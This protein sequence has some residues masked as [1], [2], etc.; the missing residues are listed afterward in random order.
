MN[1]AIAFDDVLIVPEFSTIRSRKDVDLSTSMFGRR[2]SLPIISANMDTITQAPMAMAMDEAGGAGVLHRFWSIEDN[3]KEYQKFKKAICSV[4]I[5]KLELERAEALVSNGCNALIVDVAHGAQLSVVEQVIELRKLLGTNLYITVG[6]FATGNSIND[7]KYRLGKY[8]ADAWKSGIGGGC[9][10]GDTR[11]LMSDGSYKDIK[12]IKIHDKVINMN[13]MPVEVIGTRFSGLKKYRKYK[14]NLFYKETI[15]TSDHKHWVGDYST[16][17]DINQVALYKKLDLLTKTKQSK[18]KWK[19]LDETKDTCLLL[20][21]KITFNLPSEFIIDLGEFYES[22]R[23]FK[24]GFIPMKKIKPSYELGYLIGSFLGDGT[25]SMYSKRN[26]SETSH[27]NTSAISRWFFGKNEIDL[28]NKVSSCLESVFEVKC[29]IKMQKNMVTVLNQNNF[30][31]RFF[32]Q[33][34]KKQN[35]HLPKKYLCSDKEYL[36]GIYDGLIDSDGSYCKDGRINFCNTSVHLTEL[37]MFLFYQ[38]NGYYPS[39]SRREPTAGGLKNIKIENCKESFDCRSVLNPECNHTKDY[40]ICR[41]Y[42]SLTQESEILI[43]TYD[44]EVDCSTHSF[45]ANNAIVHNSMCLTRVQTGCGIPTLGS[46]LDCSR[47][48]ENIIADG[49]IRNPGDIAKC[50]AA[51][52]DMIMIGGMLSG[53]DETPGEVYDRIGIVDLTKKEGRVGPLVKKYRGSASKESYEVQSKEASWRT[54]EGESTFVEYKGS[55]K[56]VLQNIEGG[57]R[58]S[59][60][61][62][63]AENL[64]EFKRNTS[65]VRITHA[66]NIESGAHGKK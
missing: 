21:K 50:L 7:F 37:F 63:G 65:F 43:P 4:G 1:E 16:I 25:A 56:S 41:I 15:A 58:S 9:F 5:G 2:Y 30:V 31:A 35:K 48:H 23:N 8:K 53:T 49:G 40:Q 38:T 33:F 42:D 36:K 54:H 14:N 55:V 66:G 17:K 57:L 27:R 3:V 51:G 24:D 52:A 32:T 19:R 22:R 10:A 47:D 26:S 20:P 45:I 59:F 13:G 34:D 12:D 18:F 46:I 64:E 62:V 28:A 44:I 60:T 6:N 29:K 39:T 11:I 61:Y